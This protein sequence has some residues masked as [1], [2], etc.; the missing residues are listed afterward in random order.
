ME[1]GDWRA[2]EGEEL[3]LRGGAGLGGG[4]GVSSVEIDLGL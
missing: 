3:D 2:E 1:G 4:L